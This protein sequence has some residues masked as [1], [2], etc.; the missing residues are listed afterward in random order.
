MS[1]S[2]RARRMQMS[3]STP[4]ASWLDSGQGFDVALQPGSAL[5]HPPV[6]DHIPD[7]AAVDVNFDGITCYEAAPVGRGARRPPNG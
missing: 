7:V 1:R 2:S 3:T 6:Y 5:Q 4:K